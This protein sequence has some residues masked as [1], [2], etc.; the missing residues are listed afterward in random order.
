MVGK[1]RL[2]AYFYTKFIKENMSRSRKKHP[3]ITDHGRNTWLD[4]RNAWKA[5]RNREDVSSG[6]MYRK[7]FSDICEYR[8]Y[9]PD[10]GYKAYMK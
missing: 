2:Y 8:W 7:V 3:Y 10:L 4:K 5:V 1:T 9:W 6:G